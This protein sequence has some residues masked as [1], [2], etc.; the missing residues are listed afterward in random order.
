VVGAGTAGLGPPPPATSSLLRQPNKDN[1]VILAV[2]AKPNPKEAAA[3]QAA[4]DAMGDVETLS[5]GACGNKVLHVLTGAADAALFNLAT[6]RWDTCATGAVLAAIGGRVTTLAGFPISHLP[7]SPSGNPYG[8]LLTGPKVSAEKHDEVCCALRN[9]PAIWDLFA[10]LGL[11]SGGHA[12]ALDI[13]RDLNGEPLTVKQL[14]SALGLGPDVVLASFSASEQESIR[15]KQSTACRIRLKYTSDSANNKNAPTSL[16]Y[17]RAVLR[18]LPNALAKAISAPF[19]IARDVKSMLVEA[20]VL[21]HPKVEAF[22]AAAET[23]QVALPYKAD[24]VMCSESPID[25]KFA[26]ML[27]DLSKDQGWHQCAH[28]DQRNMIKTLKALASWHAF[29]WHKDQSSDDSNNDSVPKPIL[30]GAWDK[31]SYW[32]PSHQPPNLLENLES[33]WTRFQSHFQAHLAPLGIAQEELAT[34]ATRLCKVAPKAASTAHNS[35]ATTLIHGD[36]KAANFF[37]R[38]DSDAVGIIDFQWTGGGIPGTDIAYC[39]AAGVQETDCSAEAVRTCLQT[40]LAEYHTGLLAGLIKF[41]KAAD[42]AAALEMFPRK[43]CER[44]FIYCFL[45]LAVVVF[46]DHWKT[47]TPDILDSRKGKL[48]FNAYNKSNTVAMWYVQATHMLLE[49][50]RDQDATLF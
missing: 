5:A 37:Y 1:A 43:D 39:I 35:R 49:L 46:C 12:Q 36:P 27:K 24:R 2:S 26:L 4:K 9:T 48:V 34:I 42:E 28:L 14:S 20:N 22:V 44:Q 33:V 11:E 19:K 15:Y 38:E 23:V 18:E 30:E 45:D 8:V 29:F 10:P 25:S 40:L 50:E 7:Q 31:G 16:F 17:K 6:S 47:I 21:A 13:V 3:L 32:Q 41:G